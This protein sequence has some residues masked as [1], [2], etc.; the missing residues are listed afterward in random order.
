[1]GIHDYRNTRTGLKGYGSNVALGA[2]QKLERI[3]FVRN[4]GCDCFDECEV[5]KNCIK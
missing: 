2:I 5:C 3:I 1:M 4:F